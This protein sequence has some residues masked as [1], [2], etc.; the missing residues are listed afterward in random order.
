MFPS[1]WRPG[2]RMLLLLCDFLD[3]VSMIREAVTHPRRWV[4]PVNNP[5]PANVVCVC[6]PVELVPV[7]YLAGGRL[8]V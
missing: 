8:T 3:K 5:G 7:Q 6:Y 4:R 2:R 1:P